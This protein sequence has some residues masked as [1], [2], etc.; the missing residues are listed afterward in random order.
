MSYLQRNHIAALK[1]N[2]EVPKSEEIICL[3]N[4]RKI[5]SNHPSPAGRHRFAKISQYK[6]RSGK[7]GFIGRHVNEMEKDINNVS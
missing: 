4:A 5:K 7:G 6:G 1:K 2:R 3:I